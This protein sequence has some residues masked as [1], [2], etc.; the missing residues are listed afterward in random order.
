MRSLA[1]I[2]IL[3]LTMSTLA[4]QDKQQP[5][6][7]VGVASTNCTYNFGLGILR[8]C[9]SEA[10]NLMSLAF[11]E[12]EH[13]RVGEF[14]EGYVV[15]A[16]G[17]G[18][19]YDYGSTASGW[20]TPALVSGPSATG[21]TIS[22]TTTDGRFTL[23]QAFKGDKVERDITITMTLTN[24]GPA[25]DDVRL[26]RHVDFDVDRDFAFNHWVKGFSAVWASVFHGVTL[27]ALTLTTAHVVGITEY[28]GSGNCVPSLVASPKDGDYGAFGRYHLGSLGAG[29]KKVVKFAYRLY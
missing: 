5:S 22:R 18:P 6:M 19:Y 17:A 13:I 7:D 16:T 12:W 24:N 20:G 28:F 15:C 14:I 1:L 3:L 23:V 9:V 11:G 2:G 4:A 29:K 10:G 25:L 21:V 26:L 27:G 8:W